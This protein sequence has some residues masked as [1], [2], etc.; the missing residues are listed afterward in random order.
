MI[1]YVYISRGD[2]QNTAILSTLT[3]LPGGKQSP[4]TIGAEIL[5]F[6]TLDST[7][8]HALRLLSE[9][10]PNHGTI[11]STD[12][13]TAGRGQIGR[14][15]HSAPG[16][17]L[18]LSYILYP[19]IKPQDQFQISMAVAVAVSGTVSQHCGADRVRIKWPN[20]IYVD[21][22]KIAGILIQNSIQG[23]QITACVAGIGLNVNET[24][25]PPE[26]PNP[27]SLRLELG[28]DS[29]LDLVSIRNLLS[30]H[31]QKRFE[32]LGQHTVLLTQYHDMLYRKDVISSFRLPGV[33][34]IQSG[35][36][37][38]VD[39][40]GRLIV[41]WDKGTLGVYQHREIELL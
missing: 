33:E 23:N 9:N 28:K 12:H 27:T 35:M 15:W 31:L 36:I 41:R 32:L 34:Q 14:G 30:T 8:D 3:D 26:L 38:G 17:N 25:F 37:T 11:I 18:S 7:N 39:P 6:A 40:Q 20:D 4:E 13:Q 10:R 21:D 5:H 1:D 19:A 22:R 29:L 24:D 2:G 16:L